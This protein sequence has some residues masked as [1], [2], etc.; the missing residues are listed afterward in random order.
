MW[1]HELFLWLNFD[2]GEWLDGVMV[3]AS[4]RISWLPL[5]LLI[6]WVVWRR[7]GW[8]SML[9]LA[10]AIGLAVGLS[11]LVAG[12]FKHSGPLKNLWASFPARL[13]PMHAPEF[14]GIIH[15]LR[16]GGEFGTVSAHAATSV[17]IG[18]VATL[19]IS[20]RWFSWVMWSQVVLV[21][22]SRIYLAYHFPQDIVLGVAVGLLSG[23]AMWLLYNKLNV[24]LEVK[25]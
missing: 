21:C 16:R 7:S 15:V 5:Y 12:I 3:F 13:R 6:L 2:G 23:Y 10:A 18:L 4:G 17:S 22:Y 24:K 8:R 11:D 14:E 1:D 9:L 25:R 19:A 20:R